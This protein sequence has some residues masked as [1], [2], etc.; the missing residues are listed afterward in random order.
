MEV[1]QI[2]S[3]RVY[4]DILPELFQDDLDDIED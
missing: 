1:D 4:T 2:N 3:P